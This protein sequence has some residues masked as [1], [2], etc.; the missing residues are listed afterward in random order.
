MYKRIDFG[1]LGG[2]PIDQDNLQW[3]QDSYR[4]AFAAIA[5]LVGSKVI[6]SGMA[7]TGPNISNGWLT[8]NGELLPFTGGAIGDGSIVVQE[9]ANDP[10][11]FQNGDSHVV[12][13][14]RVAVLGGPATFNYSELTNIGVLKRMW[15]PGDTKMIQVTMDY[16]AANFDATGLGINERVGWKV[17][18]GQ[19]G[20]INMSDK[21]PLGY[22]WANLGTETEIVGAG[23]GSNTIDKNQLPGDMSLS[24]PGQSGGDNSDHTNTTQFAFGDKGPGENAASISVPYSRSKAGGEYGQAY[25]PA[26]IITLYIVKI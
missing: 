7:V 24:I 1:Q 19:N 11:Q 3:M 8:Y 10:V 5:G 26:S 22:N 21:L 18:N 14:K 12:E 6:I 16:I 13:I 9:I 4:S 15:L 17:M 2:N 23:K 25:Y 20:T